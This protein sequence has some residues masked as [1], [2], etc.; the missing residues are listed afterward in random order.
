MGLPFARA[1][2]S[3]QETRAPAASVCLV[4]PDVH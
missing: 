1:V 4:Y 3:G 2:L